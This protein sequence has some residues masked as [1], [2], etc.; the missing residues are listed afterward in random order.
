[1]AHLDQYYNSRKAM[2]YYKHVL[3]LL[4]ALPLNSIL[5]VGARRSPVLENLPTVPDRVSLDRMP[6]P[7]QHGIRH[8]VHDFYTWTPDKKYD[9][10]LCLQVL[11]HLDRPKEFAA[12]LF[13]AG[14]SVLISVPYKWK[15]GA[16]KY[17]V[18][19]PVTLA[20]IRSWTGR[21]PTAHVI[22]TDRGMQ[23]VICFYAG[24]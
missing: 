21:D 18:Q 6:V 22:V 4:H 3:E 10:V 7:A 14:H 17:H 19:D 15:K 23:R 16:C 13:Q 2:N 11:E 12:K 1:M 20:K 8:I 9:I 24:H 5:D